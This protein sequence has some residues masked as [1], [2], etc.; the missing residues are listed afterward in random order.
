M[1]LS[2]VDIFFAAAMAIGAVRGM[3]R[4]LSRELADLIRVLGAFLAAYFLYRPLAT[5]LIEKSRL[6]DL[7]S[8]IVAFLLVLIAAFLL[9]TLL[10]VM[11]SKFMQFAFK[12]PLERLGGLLSGLIKGAVFA[13]VVVLLLGLWPHPAFRKAVREDSYCG[14]WL[15]ANYPGIYTRLAERYPGL[16][17]IERNLTNSVPDI[18]KPDDEEDDAAS[19]LGPAGK[20]TALQE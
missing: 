10:H 9:L 15:T 8:A 18:V 7:A 3:L 14:R 4:G 6:S 19:G 17:E 1:Q 20:D 16:L 5:L 11:L 12:G 13:S 2:V